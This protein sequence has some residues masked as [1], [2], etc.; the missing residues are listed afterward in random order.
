MAKHNRPQDRPREEDTVLRAIACVDEKPKLCRICGCKETDACYRGCGWAQPGLCSTCANMTVALVDYFQIA[1]PST[2][3]S[4]DIDILE[5]INAEARDY[6]QMLAD[7]ALPED[8]DAQRI[9]L[10]T[11]HDLKALIASGGAGR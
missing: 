8:E 11:E 6:I 5:R 1:G 3:R 9:L 7:R 10:A 4:S 2:G